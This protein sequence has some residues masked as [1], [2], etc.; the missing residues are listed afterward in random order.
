MKKSLLSIGAALVVVLTPGASFAKNTQEPTSTLVPLSTFA[1][2]KNFTT[3]IQIQPE[4]RGSEGPFYAR[5]VP[6]GYAAEIAIATTVAGGISVGGYFADGAQIIVVNVNN[7]NQYS[8][9]I[10]SGTVSALNDY[11]NC[12]SGTY[13][14]YVGNPT[15]KTQSYGPLTVYYN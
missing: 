6:P 11:V 13:E 10:I 12:P 3:S 5:N 4:A 9:P 1:N 15:T 2:A 7:Y 14:V 8:G